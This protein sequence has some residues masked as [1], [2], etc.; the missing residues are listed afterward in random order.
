MLAAALV[1][2]QV[3]DAVAWTVGGLDDVSTQRRGYTAAAWQTS[4]VL[5]RI[6][7]TDAALPVYTNGFDAL[8]LLTGRPGIPIP[9]K[10]DYLTGRRNPRYLEELAAMRADL[11]R[12]GGLL[13][14]FDAVTAR[15]SFLPS[16]QELEHALPLSKV[17]QDAVG[18]LYRFN[19]H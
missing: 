3:A 19:E 18:T 4:F 7:L 17:T 11:E 5:Y 14:Y 2:A 6:T 16:R 1:L 8:F 15:R 13:A 12:S 10:K 9:A